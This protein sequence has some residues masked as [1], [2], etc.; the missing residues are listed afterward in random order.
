VD[1]AAFLQMMADAARAAG[2]ALQECT[3]VPGDSLH[4]VL[5]GTVLTIRVSDDRFTH[6]R[7]DNVLSDSRLACALELQPWSDVL[8]SNERTNLLF[9]ALA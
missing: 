5:Q 7:R 1:P 4:S 2:W 9:S 3:P 6:A 8:M